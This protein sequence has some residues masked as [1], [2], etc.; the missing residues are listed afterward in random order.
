[1]CAEVEALF[2][3][4]DGCADVQVR[5]IVGVQKV[6]KQT[7]RLGVRWVAGRLS[8]WGGQVGA[9]NAT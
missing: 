2:R 7:W 4:G 5:G 8:W 1:M 9:P 6:V 3:A